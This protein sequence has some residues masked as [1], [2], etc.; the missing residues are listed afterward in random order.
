MSGPAVVRR[1]APTS[2]K[3]GT[4]ILFAGG[5]ALTG[6]LLGAVLST[7]ASADEQ[8]PVT[9]ETSVVQPAD[10]AGTGKTTTPNESTSD[11]SATETTKPAEPTETSKEPE[12]AKATVENEAVSSTSSVE[13]TASPEPETQTA[14]PQ[15]SN[16]LLGGLIG[17]VLNV[18]TTTVG[19]VVETVGGVVGVVDRIGD[20]VVTPIIT[21]NPCCT[22]GPAILPGTGDMLD[23]V[24]GGGSGESAGGSVTI[25]VP[26]KAVTPPAPATP[27]PRPLVPAEKPVPVAASQNHRVTLPV[28]VE[29]DAKPAPAAPAESDTHASPDGGGSGGGGG[30]PSAPVAPVAPTTT[31]QPGHDNTGGGRGPLAVLD[32]GIPATQLKLLGTGCDHEGE[33]TGREA[34]LPATSPD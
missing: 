31:V 1:H 19:G 26:A 20:Q 10:E 32:S 15:A 30:L 7:P 2:W 5:L 18:V 27:D 28:R 16:G 12:A 8:P 24:F 14:K 33:R 22:G 29:H 9:P 21:P 13:K 4:R 17:G 25:A 11:S 34:A 3:T 23:P 6:W